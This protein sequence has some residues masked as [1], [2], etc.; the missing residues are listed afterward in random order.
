M[1]G[2]FASRRRLQ[3]DV[4]YLQLQLSEERER[5]KL[6]VRPGPPPVPIETTTPH[7]LETILRGQIRLLQQMTT[8][9]GARELADELSTWRERAAKLDERLIAAQAENL[10]L[11]RELQE[12]QA[13]VESIPEQTGP[14]R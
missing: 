10:G 9:P 14:G 11:Y 1:T 2:W 5:P 3:A 4:A 7:A 8:V 6:T 13:P 12:L